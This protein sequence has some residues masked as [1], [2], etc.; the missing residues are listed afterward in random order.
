M[1]LGIVIARLGIT[2]EPGQVV[3]GFEVGQ[4]I[5]AS[6]RKEAYKMSNVLLLESKKDM[7]GRE[8]TWKGEKRYYPLFCTIC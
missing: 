5:I 2:A 1:V 8:E 4:V 7:E 3:T 6:K